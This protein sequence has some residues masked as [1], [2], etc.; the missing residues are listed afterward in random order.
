[1]DDK[2]KA[3]ES[4]GPSDQMLRQIQMMKAKVEAG[5]RKA[6]AERIVERLNA[7][8]KADPATVTA[9]AEFRMFC[10]KRVKADDCPAVPT[11]DKYGNLQLGMLGVIQALMPDGWRVVAHYSEANEIV[12]FTCREV[13]AAP[14]PVE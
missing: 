2:N 6:A 12:N 1:M 5:Q 14:A 4:G 11:E 10:N 7:V 3:G 8:L 13:E 9:L